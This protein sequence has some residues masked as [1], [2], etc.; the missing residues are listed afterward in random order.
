MCKCY[1]NNV[2]SLNTAK[3]DPIQGCVRVKFEYFQSLFS[4][5]IKKLIFWKN[6]AKMPE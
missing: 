6:A 4:V 5:R 3:T 2:F 1:E